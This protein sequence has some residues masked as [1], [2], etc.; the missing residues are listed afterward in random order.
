MIRSKIVAR[1]NDNR[2]VKGYSNNFFPN[3]LFFHIESIN[4]DSHRIEMEELKAVFFTKDFE[5]DKD[6]QDDYSHEVRGAGRKLK[7]EFNDGEVIIGYSLAYSAD[8]QGFFLTPADVNSN[9]E[10]IFVL[11]DA[12]KNVEFL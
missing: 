10:R 1:Y 12:N 5:G 4:G 11:N 6:R 7:V 8:R 9:N 3:K 2:V